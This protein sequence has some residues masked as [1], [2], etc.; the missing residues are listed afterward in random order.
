M[1]LAVTPATILT[2]ND[3]NNSAWRIHIPGEYKGTGK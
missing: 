1:E 2:M 3:A